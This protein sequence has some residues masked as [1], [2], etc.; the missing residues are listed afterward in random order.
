MYKYGVYKYK[1]EETVLVE[2]VEVDEDDMDGLKSISKLDKDSGTYVWPMDEASI[3]ALIKPKRRGAAKLADKHVVK[4]FKLRAEEGLSPFIIGS[5]ICAEDKVIVSA[6]SVANVLARKTY[7]DV[8]VPQEYLDAA[9]NRKVVRKKR[10]PITP[11]HK[12]EIKELFDEGNGLSGQQISR[13]PQFP[14]S[15]TS[16][17]TFLRKEFGF[18]K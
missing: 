9:Q 12:R 18:R 10:Q 15:V 13:L 8:D 2:T 7:A 4:I 17:N 1:D 14:Y 3:W 6:E 5:R 11:E 16:I